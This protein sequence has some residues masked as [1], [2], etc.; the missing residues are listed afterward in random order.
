MGKFVVLLALALLSPFAQ[1]QQVFTVTAPQGH[2]LLPLAEQIVREMYQPLAIDIKL[3]QLPT[4]RSLKYVNDGY[5]DAELAR[6]SGMESQFTQ[7]QAVPVPLLNLYLIVLSS[8]EDMSLQRMQQVRKGRV[9]IIHGTK[10]VEHFTRDWQVTAV[11]SHELLFNL[12]SSGRVDYILLESLWPQY[13]FPA[14]QT[15]KYF[16]RTLETV[17]MYHYVHRNHAALIPQLT[18]SV[19]QL[20]QNGRINQ[21][22]SQFSPPWH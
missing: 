2:Y 3:L 13:V 9:A 18:E 11:D 19:L 12:L 1:G 15:D 22:I 17:P 8:H 7:L 14:M 5:A 4:A 10:Y 16:Q 6:A 21:L 20:Q